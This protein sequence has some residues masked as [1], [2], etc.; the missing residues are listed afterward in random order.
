MSADGLYFG[1]IMSQKMLSLK[2]LM[3]L[4]LI[5][6]SR[7]NKVRRAFNVPNHEDWML[8][9]VT[10]YIS[11]GDRVVAKFKGKGLILNAIAV[12]VKKMI[13]S[14]IPTDLVTADDKEIL[15][16]YG[17]N[18][19]SPALKGRLCI[20][21]R[22]IVIPFECIVRIYLRGSLFKEYAKKECRAGY[23]LG[24]YLPAGMKEGDRLPIPIFTPSTKAPAG[25]H[26]ENIDYDKMVCRLTNWMRENNIV[27]WNALGLAQAIRSSSLAIALA[28]GSLA[29]EEGLIF[30]DTKF[31]FGLIPIFKNGKIIGYTIVLID[32]AMTPDSSRIIKGRFNVCKQFARDYSKKINWDGKSKISFSEEFKDQFIMNYRMI[33]KEFS[34]FNEESFAFISLNFVLKLLYEKTRTNV[35]YP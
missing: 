12:L 15:G 30:E 27:G 24:H 20:V 2:A 33:W 21:K 6:G 13:S 32:E 11:I 29:K 10:D 8:M 4:F 34:L 31:E 7:H 1:E 22:A 25:Q 5:E 9:Y 16:I 23:Y 19:M 17:Y 3:L 18:A 26:D 28:V 14:I 35:S